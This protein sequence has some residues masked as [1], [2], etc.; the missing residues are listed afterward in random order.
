MYISYLV[1][2][3]K[4]FRTAGRNR[5]KITVQNNTV[6]LIKYSHVVLP[7]MD[8]VVLTLTNRKSIYGLY[9]PVYYGNGSKD[10]FRSSNGFIFFREPKREPA[11]SLVSKK[12]NT[13]I[14]S[15]CEPI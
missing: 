9:E 15:R 13:I 1:S 7:S 6:R 12:L 8:N 5:Q 2:T 14:Y 4:P 11:Y 3:T 10:W